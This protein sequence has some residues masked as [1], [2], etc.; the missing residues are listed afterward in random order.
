MEIMNKNIVSGSERLE[1]K[2]KGLVQTKKCFRVAEVCLQTR[3]IWQVELQIN[4]KL[5]GKCQWRGKRNG[6]EVVGGST[7]T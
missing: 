6:K 4:V 1:E 7:A 5:N 3:V 2:N